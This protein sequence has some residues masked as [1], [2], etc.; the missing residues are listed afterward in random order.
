M[1]LS[2]FIIQANSCRKNYGKKDAIRNF[3]LSVPSEGI[4]GLIGRNGS[5]KTTFMK[6]C[7]GQLDV[8]SGTLK[9]FGAAPTDNLAVLSNVVYTCHNMP[10]EKHLQLETILKSYSVMFENFDLEFASKLLHYFNLNPK[11]KYKSLSQGMGSI[12]NFICGLAARAPL[13]M[14]DE[15]VLG[16]DI[17]VRKSAYEVLL[18]DFTEHPRAIIISSHMLAELE[19]ILSDILLIDEGRLVLFENIDDLRESAYRVEGEIEAVENFIKGK[20]IIYRSNGLKAE[21][22]VH[23]KFDETAGAEA[24]RLNLQ[25]GPVRPEDLC[26]Y[27]TKENKE[28][29]LSCLWQKT[30]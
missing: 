13:T 20:R 14:F 11:T 23:E 19:N 9:V 24:G 18:R 15:P 2:N 5:G 16:M 25:T 7:A 26:V 10:Y 17:T 29:E 6:L 27:L 22:V 21:A 30:N 28:G 4:I 1:I 12:F 3:T 8:T